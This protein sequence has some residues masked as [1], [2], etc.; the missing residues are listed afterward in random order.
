MSAR[1]ALGFLTRVPVADREPLT[2]ARLSAAA[3]WFPAVG[4]VVGGVLGG[5]RLLFD[6]ALPAGAATV[7]ALGAAVVV[8]GGVHED[9]VAG[10]ADG[11]GAHVGRG[12]RAGVMGDPRGGGVGGGGG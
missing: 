5:T 6:L 2:A 10:V 9:G 1:V 12:R 3:P 11:L 4:L 8:T 7:L